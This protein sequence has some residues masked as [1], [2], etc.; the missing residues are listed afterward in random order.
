MPSQAHLQLK[1]PCAL[2]DAKEMHAMQPYVAHM[3][4]HTILRQTP[5]W[6]PLLFVGMC[7]IWAIVETPG[8]Q[9]GII[10]LDIGFGLSQLSPGG[11]VQ[12]ALGLGG[13]LLLSWRFWVCRG[14]TTRSRLKKGPPRPIILN[15]YARGELHWDRI[16][17]NTAKILICKARREAAP[18]LITQLLAAG[19]LSHISSHVSCRRAAPSVLCWLGCWLASGQ[20]DSCNDGFKESGAQWTVGKPAGISKHC[21]THKFMS[22][23]TQRYARDCSWQSVPVMIRI[24]RVASFC[25]LCRR[26]TRHLLHCFASYSIMDLGLLSAAMLNG[27]GA[28]AHLATRAQDL[29]YAA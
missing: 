14:C 27:A 26:L 16:N 21:K 6:T 23:T 7:L 15:N 5:R 29:T 2:I 4:K 25:T 28:E 1:G 9:K 19:A 8:C 24:L 17:D 22:P 11:R 3:A 12:A 10:R 18:T 20:G 13:R